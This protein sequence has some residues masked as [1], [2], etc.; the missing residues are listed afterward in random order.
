MNISHTTKEDVEVL[1]SKLDPIE[2]EEFHLITKPSDR[3]A[4][5]M[6]ELLEDTEFSF[7]LSNQDSE[8]I[9]IFGVT[10]Y[11][12]DEGIP[13]LLFTP[14]LWGKNK[15]TA[16]KLSEMMISEFLQIYPK[17]RNIIWSKNIP[18]IRYVEK[19]G[20]NV[21]KEEPISISGEAFYHFTKER[22]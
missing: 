19:L 16:Y 7:T 3:N 15:L 17:L 10:S 8:A 4:N 11:E 5:Y 21:N 14:E 13:F 20:F 2:K 12:Q 9:G 22:F 6:W 18:S 1:Y